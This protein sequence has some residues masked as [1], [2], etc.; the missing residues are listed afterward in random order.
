MDEATQ[1]RIFDPFFTTKEVGKGTG[2][3][4]ATGLGVVLG[5][6][7]GDRVASNNNR[8][9]QYETVPRQVQ[10]C[11]TVQELQQRQTGFRVAYG[12]RGQTYSTVMRENPGP[13]LQVRVSVDPVVR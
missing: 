2:R 11:Q 10:Q 12:C 1:Q 6:F 4:V 3:D 5:A 7:A 9:E 13:N 8:P